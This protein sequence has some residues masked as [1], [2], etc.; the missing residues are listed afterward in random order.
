MDKFDCMR[1]I[2]ALYEPEYHIPFGNDDI[3]VE[4]FLCDNTG[5]KDMYYNGTGKTRVAKNR[6]IDAA[7]QPPVPIGEV[8]WTCRGT[9]YEEDN[10]QTMYDIL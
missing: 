9:F 4:M 3:S 10:E 8:C 1:C 7:K 5:I 6:E 2:H